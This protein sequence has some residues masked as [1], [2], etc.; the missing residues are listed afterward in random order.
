M[1]EG[2]REVVTLL[3]AFPK[4]APAMKLDTKMVL[5]VFIALKNNAGFLNFHFFSYKE[6]KASSKS[7]EAI[8]SFGFLILFP[9]FVPL[10]AG[11]SGGDFVIDEL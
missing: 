5:C 11:L 6:R 9:S 8:D 10:L 1:M 2:T 4:E 3:E 7:E